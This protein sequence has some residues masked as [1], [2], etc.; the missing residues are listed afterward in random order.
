MKVLREAITR[1]DI[2]SF[3]KKKGVKIRSTVTKRFS[4]PVYFDFNG[5]DG[6]IRF[7][8]I[9]GSSNKSWLEIQFDGKEYKIEYPNTSRDLNTLYTTVFE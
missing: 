3:L 4:D 8:S 7:Y 2:Y 6:V 5:K 1:P 9:T